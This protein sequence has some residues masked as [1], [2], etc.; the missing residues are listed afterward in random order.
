[1]EKNMTD[2]NHI[3]LAMTPAQAQAVAKWLEIATHLGLGKIEI[4]SELLMDGHIQSVEGK[5]SNDVDAFV[6]LHARFKEALYAAKTE[7][8][9]P[10]NGNFGI[11]SRQVHADT[12]H[13]Y[14]CLKVLQ[15][16]LHQVNEGSPTSIHG[17][18]LT[19]RYT[20]EPAPTAEILPTP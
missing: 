11:G 16:A 7:L 4:L 9:H 19:V 10:R 6:N 12:H 2:S 17:D 3:H 8:G 14:E 5:E 1:M 13:A 20:Q 18:G 15:K